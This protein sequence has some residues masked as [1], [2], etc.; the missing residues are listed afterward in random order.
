MQDAQH[1]RHLK[2]ARWIICIKEGAAEQRRLEERLLRRCMPFQR[3]GLDTC[4]N[5][6]FKAVLDGSHSLIGLRSMLLNHSGRIEEYSRGV[7]R[8]RPKCGQCRSLSQCHMLM[9]IDV[10]HMQTI[11]AAVNMGNAT[12]MEYQGLFIRSQ[13]EYVL[14]HSKCYSIVLAPCHGIDA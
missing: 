9:C 2:H 7:C 10:H 13:Q 12:H 5:G 4:L 1:A 3:R 14:I 8:A 6:L 11:G